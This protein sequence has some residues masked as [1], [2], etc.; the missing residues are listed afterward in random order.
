MLPNLSA[1]TLHETVSTEANPKCDSLDECRALLRKKTIQLSFVKTKIKRKEREQLSSQGGLLDRRSVARLAQLVN[2]EERLEREIQTLR[3]FVK[4]GEQAADA[5]TV[6]YIERLKLNEKIEAARTASPPQPIMLQWINWPANFDQV[7]RDEQPRGMMIRCPSSGIQLNF[8]IAYE[9]YKRKVVMKL[10]LG[11][12]DDECVL[13]KYV[14]YPSSGQGDCFYIDSLFYKV[15]ESVKPWCLMFP[16][17]AEGMPNPK[18]REYANCVLDVFDVIASASKKD[19]ALEDAATFGPTQPPYEAFSRVT[20]R[21]SAEGVPLTRTLAAVRG[22]GSYEGRGWLPSVMVSAVRE[23]VYY[24]LQ[25]RAISE[26]EIVRSMPRELYDPIGEAAQVDLAWTHMIYT[27]PL[28]N[29]VTDITQ[30]YTTVQ[31]KHPR[32][33]EFTRRLYS[34]YYCEQHAKHAVDTALSRIAE[35]FEQIEAIARKAGPAIIN[36]Y[37]TTKSMRELIAEDDALTGYGRNPA[38][39]SPFIQAIRTASIELYFFS[40]LLDRFIVNV[41]QRHLLMGATGF[42]NLVKRHTMT[43]TQ[44]TEPGVPRETLFYPGNFLRKPYVHRPEAYPNEGL[45]AFEVQPKD[46]TPDSPFP[47][48]LTSRPVR[49]DMTIRRVEVQKKN[50]PAVPAPGTPRPA[51]E[52]EAEEGAEGEEEEGEEILVVPNAGFKANPRGPIRK[53]PRAPIQKVPRRP[54]AD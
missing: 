47:F 4:E 27:T 10:P 20:R 32:A 3:N 13:F 14:D 44:E 22:W 23:E 33:P 53:V 17:Y 19:G 36:P 21:Y 40:T 34:K 11:T 9:S 37:K 39:E 46:V 30:F 26:A 52:Q 6:Y 38:N 28:D 49:D 25:A 43:Y 42:V 1:L 7:A 31:Q 51:A 12:T 8:V 50:P 24:T 18:K 35:K 48:L 5:G 15:A 45:S 54:A 29:L 41:W 16:S 2:D